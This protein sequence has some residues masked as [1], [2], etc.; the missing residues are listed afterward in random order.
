MRWITITHLDGQ[1]LR[2][3]L[4]SILQN[5]TVPLLGLADMAIVGHLGS[6]SEMGAVAVGSMIF[7]VAYWLLGFLRMG[8]SGLTAQAFG[9]GDAA[10]AQRLLR[11]SVV[12]AL[13]LGVALLL[14]Q[15]LLGKVALAVMQPS[16]DV[17][18][19]AWT[20][21][22][23]CIWGAPAVLCLQAAMG[24]FVGLHDTRTPLLVAVVQNVTNVLASLTYVYWFQWGLMGVALGT[25][26]AQWVGW[27]LTVLLLVP[28]YRSLQVRWKMVEGVQVHITGWLRL[29]SVNQVIFLRT[30]FLVAVHLTFTTVGVRQGTTLLSANALL[31]LFFTL[32]SYVMDGFAF[33]A[34]AL[35]GSRHGVNDREG[36]RQTIS[37]LFRW[38]WIMVVLFTFAYALGGEKFME[39]M[40]NQVAV[41]QSIK[42]FLP[43]T[44][45]LPI[46][47]MAAFV[48]DGI[49]IGLTSN[50]AMLLSSAGGAA[51]FFVLLCLGRNVAFSFNHVLWGAFLIYLSGRGVVLWIWAKWRAGLC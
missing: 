5:I 28:R 51:L 19:L 41:L 30:V 17:L 26:T 29:L 36:L 25:L 22:S 16:K 2:L 48:W 33:A 7:N 50:K 8:T 6:A 42:K 13:S 47:G 39:C 10:D 45:L 43:W 46:A 34:E 1:I 14:G 3:A 38:G 31:T 24:W 9:R 27:G 23:V 32:F 35:C 40:T 18:S 20:Y 15:H 21:F 49:C 37:R 11:R 4:P 12:L 44:L